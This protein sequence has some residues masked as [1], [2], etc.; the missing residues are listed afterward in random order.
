LAA[1]VFAVDLADQKK[2]TPLLEVLQR[3]G[4]ATTEAEKMGR[5][6]GETRAG[7]GGRFL[8]EL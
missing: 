8:L 1:S 6:Q 5:R 3:H 2:R 7:A 4:I